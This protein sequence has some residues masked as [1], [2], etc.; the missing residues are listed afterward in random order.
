M[1]AV[2]TTYKNPDPLFPARLAAEYLGTTEDTLS[3]WRFRKAYNL[4]Y[5]KMG[6]RVMYKKSDLDRF[7]V[8]R[9]VGG[10]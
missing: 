3:S 2:V 5:V 4:P 9:T 10:Y 6:E 7:I 1:N 8:D